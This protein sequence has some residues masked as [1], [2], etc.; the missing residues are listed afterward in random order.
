MTKDTEKKVYDF[1]AH[2]AELFNTLHMDDPRIINNYDIITD[3]LDVPLEVGLLSPSGHEKVKRELFQLAVLLNTQNKTLF[4]FKD[5]TIERQEGISFEE[6]L[7]GPSRNDPKTT[8]VFM[9]RP[10]TRGNTTVKVYV[11]Q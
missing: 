10:L 8:T 6:F 3:S 2:F 1:Q 11:E 5:G 7:T 4:I 9:S